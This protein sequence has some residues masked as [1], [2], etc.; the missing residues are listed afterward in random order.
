MKL[1]DIK[2]SFNDICQFKDINHLRGLA[3]TVL[4]CDERINE[5]HINEVYGEV[6]KVISNVSIL[7]QTEFV[8]SS[9]YLNLTDE[10]KVRFPDTSATGFPPETVVECHVY[11]MVMELIQKIFNTIT[12]R[13][14][15][16]A[17]DI[18]LSNPRWSEEKFVCLS[19]F[20]K[21]GIKYI[22]SP[23]VAA[24]LRCVGDNYDIPYKNTY[25]GIESSFQ[26]NGSVIYVD[27][28]ATEDYVMRLPEKITIQLS[29]VAKFSVEPREDCFS[30]FIVVG[31]RGID[32]QFEPLDGIYKVIGLDCGL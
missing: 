11:E 31:T 29:P 7:D 19:S 21:K 12:S 27:V 28:F 24:A 6:I 14:A 5:V 26:H 25:Q 30:D 17:L 3:Y 8:L 22:V 9:E 2:R 32:V 16:G 10:W 1:S 20:L 15:I 23:K 18:N 4:E 13:T